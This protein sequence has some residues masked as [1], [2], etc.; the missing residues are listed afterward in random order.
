M[1][2]V[3]VVIN[4][5]LSVIREWINKNRLETIILV[6]ILL[7]GAFMR[8]YRISEYMTFLGDEGRD[9]IV[10][11]RLLTDFDLI[12][13]GPGTSIGNMYLGPLYYYMMAPALLLASFSPVGP[14]AM[15]ALLGVATIFFVWYIA[16][17]WFP[18]KA[19]HSGGQVSFG[20]LIAAG[21]YA[22]T[23]VII[24]YSRSSW[25]PNIMPFFALLT[26]YSI[27]KYWNKR[28]Y[29]WLVVCGI[30][31]AFVLQSHYLGLLL[32]PVVGLFW[33]ITIIRLRVKSYRNA[34]T[35]GQK[36]F[37]KYSLL[38]FLLFLLLMSPLVIFDARHDWRNFEAI[39]VFFT[40]RQ[41]TVSARPWTALPKLWP[42]MQKVSARLI[43]GNSELAGS[44]AVRIIPILSFGAV[45]TSF[46]KSKFKK[47]KKA[48]RRLRAYL[49]LAVWVG[50]AMVGLGVYKQEIYDH[51]YGF[52]F[53]APFLLLGGISEGLIK[54]AKQAGLVAVVL[55]VGWL[56]YVNLV[57]NPLK[58]HPNRQ[59]QRTKE[60]ARAV[61]EYSEDEPFN[62]AV[63]AER[64]Y[65]GAYM[66]FLEMWGAPAMIP[67]ADI[68]DETLTE[69]LFVVC[70]VKGERC[71]PETNERPELT[72]F[73]WRKIVAQWDVAGVTVS[74]LIRTQ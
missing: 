17:E 42:L 33:F 19:S 56:S 46:Y 32:G 44:I 18:P 71:N 12:L 50:I 63:I 48:N 7:I 29:K 30:S 65:E 24:I 16:R 6:T 72:N 26:I 5:Q 52:F 13:V 61:I 45:L 53:A 35:D 66:Y 55:M 9:V 59:L 64:N 11:R 70:E 40:Q 36:N 22:I 8:L 28:E 39:K 37:L 1:E 15:I 51:Y 54:Y 58:Y 47:D 49:L 2:K 68:L 57:N 23:P 74:K 10:V 20:P 31:F 4:H 34:L 73:G 69:Q 67:I 14:A 41:T 62:F 25:N 21:L 38:S 43:T 27:W 3:E 60:I